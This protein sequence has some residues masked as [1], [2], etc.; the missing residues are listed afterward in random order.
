MKHLKHASENICENTCNICVKHMQYP[1]KPIF[2]IRLNKQMKHLE[3]TLATYVHSHCN[4]RNI[5]IYFYNIHTKHLKHTL[6]TCTGQG[7]VN[8]P[9]YTQ[10][11]SSP[12][13]DA[14]LPASP[15]AMGEVDGGTS[16]D[17]GTKR[18]TEQRGMGA[19]VRCHYAGEGEW[20]CLFF[21][22]ID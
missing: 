20:R 3:Q 12:G 13:A 14:C 9:A 17:G 22:K 15:S 5:P 21:G 4:I 8:C 11:Q 7:Y 10:G 18:G 1:N 6:A 2:N 19:Q 16:Q